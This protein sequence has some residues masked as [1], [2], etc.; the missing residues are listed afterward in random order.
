ME[1]SSLINLKMNLFCEKLESVQYKTALAITGAIQDTSLDKIYQELGLESLKSRNKCKPL[2]FMFKIRKKEAPNH[3]INSVPKCE[4][5]IRTR[6]N[7][8]PTCN[9]QTDCFI[10]SFFPFSLNYWFNLDFNTSNLEPI[11]IFK[12]RLL[13]FIRSVQT[14]IYN[15][16]DPK[17]LTF[18]T[19]QRLILSH[20][21]E[22][23]FLHNF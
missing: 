1:I 20:L 11:L 5:N 16:F 3:L 15:S 13:S 6:S 22:H 19:R 14:N 4:T 7:N 10:F 8:T 23:R 12:S 2:S 17:G 21:N 9:C 18:L